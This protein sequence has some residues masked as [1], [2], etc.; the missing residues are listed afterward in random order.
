M[1]GRLLRIALKTIL[2]LLLFLILIV[3]L[4]QT[5]PVQNFIRGKAVTWLQNK[6][7]TRVDVGRV[8]IDFPKNIVLENI[9]LEDQTKDTLFSGGKIKADI[10]L[11]KLIKGNVEINDVWLDNITAKVKRNLPDTVFNFQFIID[12]FVSKDKAPAPEVKDTANNFS[13]NGI[14]LNKI[15]LIYKDT[16]TGND[17]EA[18]IGHFETRLGT[19]DMNHMRFDV[20]RFNLSDF[21]VKVYQSKPL[22]QSES[23]FN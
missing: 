4:I 15:R 6:L 8:Y 2:F 12:A 7:K 10:S 22:V 14:T 13:I 1:G 16:V 5:E 19:F 17:A 11:L 23:C 20:S 18:M 3:L 9:Y 21:T